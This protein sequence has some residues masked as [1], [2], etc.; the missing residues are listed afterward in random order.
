MGNTNNNENTQQPY[1]VISICFK[2]SFSSRIMV[3]MTAMI[4]SNN[5]LN[6]VTNIRPFPRM[7]HVIIQ[8]SIP[9]AIT[10]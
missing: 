9:E 8:K 2:L 5:G 6:I 3:I 4:M 7:Q 10:L 1:N